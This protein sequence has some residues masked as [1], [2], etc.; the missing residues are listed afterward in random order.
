LD[1]EGL[2]FLGTIQHKLSHRTLI[3]KVWKGSSEKGTNPNEVALSTLDRRVL[4]LA[5]VMLDIP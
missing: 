4:N 2:N 1:T 5:G 3:V